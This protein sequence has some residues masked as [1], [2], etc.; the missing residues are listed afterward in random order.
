MSKKSKVVSTGFASLV[1]ALQSRSSQDSQATWDE[2]LDKLSNLIDVAVDTKQQRNP[3]TNI[4]NT[5]LPVAMD[6]I[7]QQVVYVISH[8]SG[9]IC[10]N[11]FGRSQ[12]YCQKAMYRNIHRIL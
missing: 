2:L 1:A 11:I 3:Q 10:L 7:L 5:S 4:G 6:T 9:L 12:V 8:V